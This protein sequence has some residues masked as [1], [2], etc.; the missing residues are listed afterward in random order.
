MIGC[1]TMEVKLD[2]TVQ[3]LTLQLK[4]NKKAL[5]LNENINGFSN[6]VDKA[7]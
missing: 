6:N 1:F 3:N 4:S 2:T 7:H 5:F